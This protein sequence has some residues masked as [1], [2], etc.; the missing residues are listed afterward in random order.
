MCLPH[1]G[2]EKLYTSRVTDDK[3]LVSIISSPFFLNVHVAAIA[4]SLPFSQVILIILVSLES[5]YE[6]E[7]VSPSANIRD[8]TPNTTILC[9]ILEAKQ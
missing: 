7:R 1:V 3:N 9:N 4:L 2:L 5:G 8:T 6:R